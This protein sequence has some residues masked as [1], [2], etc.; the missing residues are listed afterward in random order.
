MVFNGVSST[1]TDY[2]YGP[3]ESGEV[4]RGFGEGCV[5]YNVITIILKQILRH[6]QFSS[7]SLDCTL[8][9]R[10]RVQAFPLLSQVARM[11]GARTQNGP[12]WGGGRIRLLLEANRR[13]GWAP[14]Y[15]WHIPV[16]KTLCFLDKTLK[17]RL[18]KKQK[19]NKSTRLWTDM[20]VFF[21][22]LFKSLIIPLEPSIRQAPEPC[23]NQHPQGQ[24]PVWC[25]PRASKVVLVLELGGFGVFFRLV[26][27]T[28]PLS[29]TPLHQSSPWDLVP[30]MSLEAQG[31]S[32]R[33]KLFFK[34]SYMT[35]YIF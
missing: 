26:A 23:W 6:S 35:Y 34:T 24:N 8:Y 18:S 9:R 12:L 4:V 22:F 17:H 28:D 27:G 15:Y 30:R 10:C 7:W 25:E 14:L 29:M 33:F 21:F 19:K 20:V 3:F 31:R 11:G 13:G 2:S 16:H 5:Y 1:L 32:I